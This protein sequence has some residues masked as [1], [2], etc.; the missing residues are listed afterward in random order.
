MELENIKK[1]IAETIKPQKGITLQQLAEKLDIKDYELLGI[2]ELLKQDGVM[3]DVIDN[4]VFKVKSVKNEEN[5]YEIKDPSEEHK[6]LLI[7]DTHLVNKADRLDILNYLY[8]KADE[9]GVKHILHCGDLL[10]GIYS[11]RPQQLL[12]LKKY[13]FD[14]HLRYVVDKYPRFNGSTYFIGGNHQDTY[15]RN[16]GADIGKAIAREREDMNY[17]DQSTAHIKIGNLGILLHHGS[18]GN[19][20]SRT[21]KIQRY[22]ET[23]PLDKKIDIVV[24]G[25]YHNSG[26][27]HYLGKHCFQMGCLCDESPFVRSMGLSHER[28]CWWLDVNTDNKGNVV[29]ITPKLETFNQKKL[30][31]RR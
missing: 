15:I 7:S 27:L 1:Y 23:L 25:H 13:G 22:V 16:G 24:M 3:I 20:Y 31:K 19:A 29:D 14:E 18:G 21:Y 26:Y 2:I 30:I 10:D 4:K 8:K 9:K 28:S 12:E 6:L 5:T 11:N 17:L